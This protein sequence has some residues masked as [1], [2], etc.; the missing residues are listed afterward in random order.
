MS[1]SLYEQRLAI[2]SALSATTSPAHSRVHYLRGWQVKAT[3]GPHQPAYILFSYSGAQRVIDLRYSEGIQD[4]NRMTPSAGDENPWSGVL[5]VN[6]GLVMPPDPFG[7]REWN[8]TSG[9]GR[10]AFIKRGGGCGFGEKIWH[11]ERSGASA[12]VIFNDRKQSSFRFQVYELEFQNNITVPAGMINQELG[13]ELAYRVRTSGVEVT[14]PS[15]CRV[16]P[17]NSASA[18]GS[19]ALTSCVC[20][21]WYVGPTG[22]PCVLPAP[23]TISTTLMPTTT[24]TTPVPTTTSTT[25]APTT[26]SSTTP[27]M[28]TTPPTHGLP[29]RDRRAV[30]TAQPAWPA[31]L[32]H[33]TTRQRATIALRGCSR[34]T[35][36]G[37]ASVS[38]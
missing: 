24:S 23:T 37:R 30:S 21:D 10:I 34:R 33:T 32:R 2:T 22:G 3:V 12:V 18:P 1:P 25:P 7:C 5:L 31:R 13:E 9:R 11:A 6:V 15:Y 14:A 27:V 19:G 29:R 16:C 17:G 8:N 26:T 20:K 35:R 36:I 4:N 28:I 38:A